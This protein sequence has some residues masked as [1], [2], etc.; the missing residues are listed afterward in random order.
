MTDL[1]A[2][3]QFVAGHGRLLERRRFGYLFGDDGTDAATVLAALA[4]YRNPDGGIGLLEPDLRAPSSQPSAVLY[5][6]EI[7]EELH[8]PQTGTVPLAPTPQRT[9]TVPL[10]ATP[11]R[12]GTVPLA[13]EA[14]RLAT[15]ALD[16]LQTV[17]NPDGGVPFVLPSAAGGP[18]S[19]WMVPQDG[20]PSA[21]L[22]TAG[23][24][25]AALRLGL[26]HP[27]L[28]GATE[29]V[30]AAV[31]DVK[32]TEPYSFRFAISF[33]DAVHDR[34]P[35]RAGAQLD[36]FA[37]RM[38]AD[39]VLRVAA[40][41]EGETLGALEV[42]PRPDHAG[43]RLFPPALIEAELDE[44]AAG[45]QDDGGWTFSWLAW[46]PAAAWEWRG[47]V[48]VEALKVLRAERRL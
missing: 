7:L 28:A 17:S 10:A 26:D 2:A 33:L 29:Y 27:W 47:V 41:V 8:A 18:H 22:T 35:A 31:P 42:A 44:L 36:A 14:A 40:G 12:T 6:L 32:L 19:P 46:N 5:A 15:G 45:Q 13:P 39:G 37:D 20:N 23:L 48:T 24:V 3:S 38:P 1:A 30:W 16:W 34:D 43:R 9:G 11:Q 25:A 4:A 21:L